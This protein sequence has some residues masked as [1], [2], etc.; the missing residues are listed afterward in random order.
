MATFGECKQFQTVVNLERG[1]F[2]LE[3]TSNAHRGRE[4]TVR[5]VAEIADHY[6]R[7]AD[8]MES[9]AAICEG[10]RLQ[11]PHRGNR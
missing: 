7:G 4:F 8:P 3:W 2:G 1:K 6:L 5:E 9:A 10:R 11:Y